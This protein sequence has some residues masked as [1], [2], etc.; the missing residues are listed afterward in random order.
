VTTER[1]ARN[2]SVADRVTGALGKRRVEGGDPLYAVLRWSA[3]GIFVAV[4]VALVVSLVWQSAPGFHHAGFGF[5][6]GTNWT[7]SKGSYGAG[8]FIVDT[9]LTT[10]IAMIVVIPVGIGTAAALA[11]F[12]ARWISGPLS[13]AIDLLAAV[14]SIVVGLWGV[15]ILTPVFERHVEPFFQKTPVL[16]SLSSGIAFGSGIL[17]AALVLAI[18]SLPTMVALT[19]TAIRG[20]PVADREAALALGATRWQVVSKVVLP[21]ARSGIQAAGT[22]AI[23]RALGEAI[24]V[25]LVIGGGTNFPHSLLSQG[26]TLGSAVVSFFGEATGLERS[27][28]IGLVVVLLV[29]TALVNIGGQ[30]LLLRRPGSKRSVDSQGLFDLVEGLGG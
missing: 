1:A 23:G 10:G 3:A 2:P 4:V 14:P 16:K 19:R 22:L 11:E 15:I 9:L 27:S 26:T 13:T 28:V 7:P 30:W 21:G 20:V 5:V 17:L 29:I 24:A 8:V 25:A 18:M 12:S 6:F